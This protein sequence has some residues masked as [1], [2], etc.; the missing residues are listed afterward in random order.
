MKATEQRLPVMVGD[1]P[2]LIGFVDI[3]TI[4]EDGIRYANDDCRAVGGYPV[5]P[6]PIWT[7]RSV[8]MSLKVDFTGFDP[9]V[10][11]AIVGGPL[12]LLAYEASHIDPHWYLNGDDQ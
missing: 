8:R 4:A 7:G 5:K 10:L 1:H 3:G 12:G 11:A 9:M 6:P 2:N